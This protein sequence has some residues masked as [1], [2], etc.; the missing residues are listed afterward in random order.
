MSDGQINGSA[1]ENYGAV[2]GTIVQTTYEANGNSQQQQPQLEQDIQGLK[3]EEKKEKFWFS[4]DSFK[5]AFIGFIVG[6]VA[7]SPVTYLH[8]FSF[9]GDLVLNDVSQFE[10]DSLMGGVSAAAFAILYRYLFRK[11]RNED[12][13]NAMIGA[14]V[15]MRS[16]NNLQVM[17]YCDNLYCGEPLG[18]FDWNMLKQLFFSLSEDLFLFGA[19]AVVLEYYFDKGFLSRKANN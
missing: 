18:V 13:A 11:E 8:N 1:N 15:I 14:C 12:E 2:S 9:P 19:V 6:P 3:Q 4:A 16:F 10:F 5:A 7:I 17:Y